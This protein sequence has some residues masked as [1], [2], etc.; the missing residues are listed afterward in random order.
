MCCVWACHYQV[1]FAII[2]VLRSV[3]SSLLVA[4]CCCFS[5]FQLLL[6]FDVFVASFRRF[7]GGIEPFLRRLFF[8]GFQNNS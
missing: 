6:L 2:P 1:F 3:L 5:S 8:V 7:L 4:V